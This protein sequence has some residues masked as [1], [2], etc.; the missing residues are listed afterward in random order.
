MNGK[1]KFIKAFEIGACR[2]CLIRCSKESYKLDHKYLGRRWPQVTT[3]PD[4]TLIQWKNLGVGKL[5]RTLRA[6][7]IYF[8]SL[9]IIIGNLLAITYVIAWQED[10]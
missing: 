10:Y 7:S 9:M 2:R 3:A 5:Q 1:E 6:C 8:I 4:P